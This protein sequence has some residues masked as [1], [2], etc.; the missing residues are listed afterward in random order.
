MND[1]PYKVHLIVE[2]SEEACFFDIVKELGVCNSIELTYENACGFGNVASFYQ[3][4]ISQEEY[5]CVLCVYDVDFR[6][7]ED[8]SPYKRVIDELESILGDMDAVKAVSFCTNPNILQLL[9]LGCDTFD[10]VAL[11]NCS[12]RAN[13]GLVHK[14]WDKIGR[15]NDGKQKKSSLYDAQA[16]QLEII[17]NSYIYDE[18][19][20][21]DY[22]TLLTNCASVPT[23]Y[24]S[25]IPG[26]NLLKL[27]ES[28]RDGSIDFF[29][30]IRK[31][32]TCEE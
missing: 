22:G 16:W 1:L 30:S 25:D 10:K 3:N 11:S 23:D 7:E 17:K 29:E 28:L 8:G 21:Y 20:S 31:K 26:T 13:T 18:S 14:Y 4:A 9:L 32:Y 5:D 2:G 27:L 6:Q 12:K 24:L 15:V 19:P